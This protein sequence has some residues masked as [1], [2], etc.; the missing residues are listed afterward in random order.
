VPFGFA[1][2]L[3]DRDTGLV[4]F[5]A[6]DYD[7]ATGKWTAKDPIDFFGGDLN[8]YGYVRNNPINSYDANGL[9]TP[10][11]NVPSGLGKIGVSLLVNLILEYSMNNLR[12]GKLRGGL[13]MIKGGTELYAGAL[14]F[15]GAFLLGSFGAVN[16]EP[17]TKITSLL[18]SAAAAAASGMLISSGWNNIT[19]G[20]EEYLIYS[21]FENNCPTPHPSFP[22]DIPLIL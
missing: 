18:G 6:R 14:A 22:E 21:E 2:G 13:M 4:R 12:P 7:P 9:Y 16:P 3:H 20:R 15:K 19:M 8:L 10:P 5:G 1:G 17:I 11:E